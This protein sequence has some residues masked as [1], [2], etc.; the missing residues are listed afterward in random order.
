LVGLS[1][2]GVCRA[3]DPNISALATRLVR[4]NVPGNCSP[5]AAGS[6]GSIRAEDPLTVCCQ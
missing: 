2:P 5:S 4:V 6:K 3:L 1:L